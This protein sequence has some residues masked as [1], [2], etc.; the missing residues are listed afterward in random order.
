MATE[1]SLQ[2]ATAILVERA[3]RGDQ[4]AYDRLFALGA[5][6]ALLFIRLRLGAR[7]R[8]KLDPMDV[9][10]EAYLEAHKAFPSFSYTGDDA[11]SRWLNRIIENCIRGLADHHGAKKRKPPGEVRQVSRVLDQ[12]R[13]SG[14][15]P[16]TAADRLDSRDRLARAMEKL[17]EE[18]RQVLLMRHFEDLTVDEIAHRLGRSPSATRRL[19]GRATTRLGTLLESR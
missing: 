7:L 5:D 14:T 11:F 2:R 12:I 6:R 18:D 15:G 4:E 13:A 8:S 17:E 19:L 9:L 16:V 10:Q 3:Q 1:E